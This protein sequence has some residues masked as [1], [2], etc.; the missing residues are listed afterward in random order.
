[1]GY[2]IAQCAT[3]VL[4]AGAVF[5]V[6]WTSLEL[7]RNS[8]LRCGCTTNFGPLLWNL[9]AGVVHLVA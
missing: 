8:I 7:D 1:M 4:V 6:V 9:L 3:D 2:R 5:N